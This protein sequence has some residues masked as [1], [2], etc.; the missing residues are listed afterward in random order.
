VSA[1]LTRLTTLTRLKR[2]GAPAT[3]RAVLTLLILAIAASVSPTTLR[4]GGLDLP[5]AAEQGLQV[6]Y[7]GHPEQA[8][9]EFRRMQ[10]DAPDDPLGYILEADAVWWQIYCEACQIK[11]NIMDAWPQQ[12]GNLPIDDSYLLL[13]EKAA[14]LAEAQIA[15][16]DSAKMRLYAGMGW[17][18]KARLLALRNERR[19][20]ARAGVNARTHLLRCLELD[21]EMSDAYTGLGL[22]NYYV[23]T[24]SAMAKALR[25]LMGIPGGDKADGI[26]QLRIAI[27]HGSLTRVEAQFYLAKNL[28]IYEHDKAGSVELFKSLVNEFPAN[29]IFQLVLGDTLIDMGRK[30]EA[31]E[32]LRAA[33]EIPVASVGCA[34]HVREL[35]RQSTAKLQAD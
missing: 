22:Y 35:V 30:E 15:R 12:R 4:A 28:R 9:P 25:F 5:P 29:P 24:L 23:D 13:T 34:A 16:T 21:P 8:I 14:S 6:L 31:A 7:S 2:C 17:M 33:E 10:T 3:P 18:L 26:R 11:W 19:A 1:G 32:T 20:T 27:Q